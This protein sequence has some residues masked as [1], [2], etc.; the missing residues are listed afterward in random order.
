MFVGGPGQERPR[1]VR[2]WEWFTDSG[3]RKAYRS[4]RRT[5]AGKVDLVVVGT[6]PS[7]MNVSIPTTLVEMWSSIP[8]EHR[9]RILAAFDL[10][11]QAGEAMLE[12]HGDDG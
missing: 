8:R 3:V 4:S 11:D 9:E 10:P 5:R 2:W 1:R 12:W 6:T 7:G